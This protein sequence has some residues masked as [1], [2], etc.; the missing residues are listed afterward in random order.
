[1][2]VSQVKTTEKDGCNSVQVGF[3][4]SRASQV[5][6]AAKNHLV[7]AGFENGARFVREI[8]SSDPV[9]A[10]VGQKIALTSLKKGDVVALTSRSRG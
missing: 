2:V 4:P 5:T 1:M 10:E 7:K 6:S 9:T 3:L 8:R